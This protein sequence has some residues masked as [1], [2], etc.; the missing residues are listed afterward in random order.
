MSRINKLSFLFGRD[1]AGLGAPERRAFLLWNTLVP[2]CAAMG[3][4]AAALLL[5]P[6]SYRL[7]IFAGYFTHPLIF[8]ANLAPVLLL[9]LLGWAATGRPWAGYLTAA[10]PVTLLAFGNY[11]KLAFRDDPVLFGDLFILGEAG[12][13]AGQYHLFLDWRTVFVLVCVLGGFVFMLLAVRARP[14]GSL[15]AAAALAALLAVL[16][17]GRAYLSD[18]LYNSLGTNMAY[19]NQWSDTHRYISRGNI[20]PF[21]HSL[22]EAFPS[23][24]EGYDGQ[25]AAAEIA[26]YSDADIPEGE[27]VNIICLMLESFADISGFEGL[28]LAQDVYAEYHALEAESYSGTLVTNIFAGNTVNSERAFLTGMSTQY[29]WRQRVNSYVWYLKSQGYECWGDHPCYQWFYNR[30]NVNDYLGFDSYRFVENYYNR[31]SD[32]VS[33]DDVFFPELAAETAERLESGAP[34]FS[35]SV[36]YQGHGPYDTDRCIWGEAEDFVANKNLDA[37]SLNILANYLGSVKDTQERLAGFVDSLRESGEPVVLVVFGDHKP[38]L[39]NANSVYEALGVNLDQGTE[40]GF[41]NYW[42]TR[43]LFWANDAA[44]AVLDFDFSGEGPALSPCF[45]MG[46]LFDLLGWPGDAYNQAIAPI[47]GALPV[48]HDSAAVV[49]PDGTFS[50]SPT[51]SQQERIKLYHNLEYYHSQNFTG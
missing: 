13:M 41:Y 12:E 35:F 1:C 29:N 28:E 45:L 19:L 8:L 31:Y 33:M 9:M 46:S 11:Y 23:P 38:W 20:Y 32:G 6:G 24:P 36:T 48:I 7:A 47:R 15:R 16:L 14:R 21:F 49:T 37:E 18:S 42:S 2:L 25:A 22:G 17:G 30:R 43:Y 26:K 34:Q 44:K 51:P 5:A 27:K 4:T 3:I 40:E 39:G 50:T 10:L